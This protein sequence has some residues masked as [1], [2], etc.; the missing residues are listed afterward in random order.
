MG[1][2]RLQGWHQFERVETR[3]ER[4]P[5]PHAY[6][7][8]SW[9]RPAPFSDLTIWDVSCRSLINAHAELLREYK[10]LVMPACGGF[11]AIFPDYRHPQNTQTAYQLCLGH[12]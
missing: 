2:G 10:L 6:G 8:V 5:W 4:G 1:L 11:V 3:R 9:I 7:T 12:I